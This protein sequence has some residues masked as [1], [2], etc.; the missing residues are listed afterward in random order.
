MKSIFYGT[1]VPDRLPSGQFRRLMEHE[2]PCHQED[3]GQAMIIELGSGAESE[4]FVRLQSWD[5]LREH[6]QMQMLIGKRI[7]VTVEVLE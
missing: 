6:P 5:T 3:G 7:S 1:V 4:M 2:V